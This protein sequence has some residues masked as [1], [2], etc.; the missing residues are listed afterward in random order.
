M[1]PSDQWSFS[2]KVSEQTLRRSLRMSTAVLGRKKWE[3]ILLCTYYTAVHFISAEESSPASVYTWSPLLPTV[4]QHRSSLSSALLMCHTTILVLKQMLQSQGRRALLCLFG[5]IQTAVMVKR[6]HILSACGS[7][8]PQ[9][10]MCTWMFMW[11][12]Y[13]WS[14]VCISWWGW[15]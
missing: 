13:G 1:L 15:G 11:C 3:E 4:N 6:R 10:L 9:G 2:S 14:C 7:L 5:L 12:A 8:V